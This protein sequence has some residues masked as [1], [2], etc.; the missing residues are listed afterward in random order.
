MSNSALR[1]LINLGMKT[2]N[3]TDSNV[4]LQ[5]DRWVFFL[6]FISLIIHNFIISNNYPY[7][8]NASN[9]FKRVAEQN[10]PCKQWRAFLCDQRWAMGK[11]YYQWAEYKFMNAGIENEE[12][13]NKLRKYTFWSDIKF[14]FEFSIT[15]LLIQ[16]MVV[17]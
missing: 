14:N 2:I 16:F 5:I 1:L 8:N 12:F 4:I 6:S 7:A 15:Y 3:P 13:T 11:N 17:F 9:L 10:Y